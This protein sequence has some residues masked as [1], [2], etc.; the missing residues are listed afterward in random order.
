MVGWPGARRRG[1]LTQA[2]YNLGVQGGSGKPRFVQYHD[3]FPAPIGRNTPAR[4]LRNPSDCLIDK[5]PVGAVLCGSR[6]FLYRAARFVT[7]PFPAA[8]LALC[9]GFR[10]RKAESFSIQVAA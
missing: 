2:P 1:T 10:R 3:H 6:T 4:V 9:A 8:C 7:F 5:K